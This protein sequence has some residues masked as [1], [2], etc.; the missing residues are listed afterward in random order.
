VLAAGQLATPRRTRVRRECLNH[1]NDTVVNFRR[2][3][4]KIFLRTAFKEDAIHCL[5]TIAFGEVVLEGTIAQRLAAR[6]P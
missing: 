4:G 2:Q 3:P 6:P 1:P 5:L